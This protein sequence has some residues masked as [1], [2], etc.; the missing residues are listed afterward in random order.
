VFKAK[1]ALT[2]GSQVQLTGNWAKSNSN[3][4]SFTC[5]TYQITSD[6]PIIN[7]F[8]NSK[9]SPCP[10]TTPE[11]QSMEKHYRKEH[12]PQAKEVCRG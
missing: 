4:P 6:P 1:P 3:R 12:Y 5:Q 7:C 9:F 10:F 8:Y 11:S 2:K